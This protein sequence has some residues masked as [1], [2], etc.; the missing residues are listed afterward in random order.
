M[1]IHV[2]I[3][4]FSRTYL[5]YSNGKGTENAQHDKSLYACVCMCTKRNEQ[6]KHI[7]Q[8]TI[9]INIAMQQG[10]SGIT[11]YTTYDKISRK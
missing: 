5:K 4:N 2:I 7:A 6:K 3:S 10:K 1:H 11:L 9:N 8:I